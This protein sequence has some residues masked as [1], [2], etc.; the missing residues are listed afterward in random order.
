[1]SVVSLPGVKTY[2]TMTFPASRRANWRVSA[3]GDAKDHNSRVAI[4]ETSWETASL[5]MIWD[6]MGTR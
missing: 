5:W 6:G 1:M 3:H 2:G 4:S